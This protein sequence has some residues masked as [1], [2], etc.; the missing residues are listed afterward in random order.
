MKK[1]LSLSLVLVLVLAMGA[2]AFANEG[3]L[4]P[5]EQLD[6]QIP[7]YAT[8]GPYA[9]VQYLES[10]NFGILLG[11][12][13]EYDTNATGAQNGQFKLEANTD[14]KIE[15]EVQNFDW[16]ASPY[17]FVVM[18]T[19]GLVAYNAPFGNWN[20]VSPTNSINYG[21]YK[22]GTVFDIAGYIEIKSISQQKADSYDTNI[23]VT[24]SK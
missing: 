6:A 10:V 23:L 3:S 11:A 4:N 12:V 1:F 24:V 19:A 14:V 9:A 17:K 18:G 8:I 21:Y 7:V 22:G 13:D 20:G 2:M 16:I 5:G 15:F